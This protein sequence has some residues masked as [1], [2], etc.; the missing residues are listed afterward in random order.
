MNSSS[1]LC[2]YFKFSSSAE[3]Q[4]PTDSLERTEK[5][6]RAGLGLFATSIAKAKG[7]GGG[8][9]EEPVTLGCL[10]EKGNAIGNGEPG[11]CWAV[12][13]FFKAFICVHV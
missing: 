7:G 12:V 13:L 2:L 8:L 1:P 11:F 10:R 3:E 6:S 9:Y 5:P 4:A